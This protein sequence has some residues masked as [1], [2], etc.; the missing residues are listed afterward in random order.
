LAR[1]G[2]DFFNF[3]GFDLS[4]TR[5]SDRLWPASRPL[6]Y[7]WG[8]EVACWE[9]HDETDFSGCAETDARRPVFGAG[10]GAGV[11]GDALFQSEGYFTPGA[12]ALRYSGIRAGH[13]RNH[14]CGA[15]G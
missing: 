9:P 13:H 7:L 1:L 12:G 14:G 2:N 6:R 15:R 5:T 10:G 3:G 11:A 4:M 8:H